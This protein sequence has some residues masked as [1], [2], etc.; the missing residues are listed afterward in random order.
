MLFC[1]IEVIIHDISKDCSAFIFRVKQSH[2]LKMKAVHMKV[3]QS[4]ETSGRVTLMT[5]HS[6][7]KKLY[8][9]QHKAQKQSASVY[10][11][12]SVTELRVTL[13]VAGESGR[14][15]CQRHGLIAVCQSQSRGNEVV[16]FEFVIMKS[17]NSEHQ[18]VK[19]WESVLLS[20]VGEN[21]YTVFFLCGKSSGLATAV[22]P[23]RV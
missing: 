7:S 16:I 9:Q 17:L 14:L 5:Q 20:L 12:Q 8:L 21:F 1:V 13:T 18:G 19:H 10:E 2:A 6:V 22:K 4:L 3:L 15:T 11:R 23:W